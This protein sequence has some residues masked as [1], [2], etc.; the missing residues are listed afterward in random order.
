MKGEATLRLLERSEKYELT[1]PDY[2]A[3]GILIG[4]LL[5]ETV[6]DVKISCGETGFVAEITFV[7]KGMF[8]GTYNALVGKIRDRG[9]N[10]VA[11][12][13]G[14]WDEIIYITY[15]NNNNNNNNNKKQVL[16]DATTTK[17]LLP[18]VA[19]IEKQQPYE[20]RKLWEKVT[21]G[22]KAKDL[23]AATD[24]KSFLEQRQRDEAKERKEN[25]NK[26]WQTTHFEDNGSGG[27]RYKNVP[28]GVYGKKEMEEEKDL[29]VED[30]AAAGGGGGGGGRSNHNNNDVVVAAASS[31][32][33]SSSSSSVAATNSEAATGNLIDI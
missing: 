3:R 26:E 1:F 22:I 16:F 32:S 14:M 18:E 24:G 10:T 21:A 27:W 20:S 12:I 19:P 8:T 31:S 17:P 9:G 28:V 30:D 25:N 11:T 7:A 29:D 2:Y 23:D 4:K 6:G 15:K 13:E 33:S 5:M